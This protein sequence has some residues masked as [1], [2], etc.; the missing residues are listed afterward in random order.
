MRQNLL[1]CLWFVVFFCDFTCLKFRESPVRAT[2]GASSRSP[3]GTWCGLTWHPHSTM[4]LYP[5]PLC[6][7]SKYSNLPNKGIRHVSPC[8][9]IEREI[10][11][12]F[13]GCKKIYKESFTADIVQAFMRI[14][15]QNVSF[16][17]L[18]W[19]NQFRLINFSNSE[20]LFVV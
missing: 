17:T 3:P 19:E 18:C 5:V 9:K 4:D 1:K 16:I 6:L 11:N 8:K 7:S 13:C 12:S 10:L 2:V 20:S 14:Y 15:A